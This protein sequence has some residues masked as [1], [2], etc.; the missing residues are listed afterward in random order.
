MIEGD[1]SPIDRCIEVLENPGSITSQ[2]ALDV[3]GATKSIN[4]LFFRQNI[5]TEIM[6]RYFP[7]VS[8]II[9]NYF[10]ETSRD[11]F[12][13]KQKKVEKEKKLTKFFGIRPTLEQMKHQ[14]I[15]EP[16]YEDSKEPSIMTDNSNSIL[17]IPE[18][19]FKRKNLNV[20]NSYRDYENSN[21][22]NKQ[23]F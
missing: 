23:K 14:R 19:G 21:F 2:E 11:E 4:S 10:N 20:H 9:R 1:L 22:L 3:F 16:I 5:L 18:E 17:P 6:S 12:R 8:P 13:S 7:I 15:T